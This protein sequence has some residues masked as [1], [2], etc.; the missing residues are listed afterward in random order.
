MGSG[1]TWYTGLDI[2]KE[3]RKLSSED[4]Q[5]RKLERE[6]REL[7]EEN[8]TLKKAAAYFAKNQK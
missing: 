3:N 1:N 4:E 6:I 7:R 8:E 5:V 2:R